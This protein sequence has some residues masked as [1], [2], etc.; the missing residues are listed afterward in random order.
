MLFLK[1]IFE[2]GAIKEMTWDLQYTDR[3]KNS[4]VKQFVRRNESLYVQE[5]RSLHLKET[6]L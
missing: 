3:K 5:I 1:N 4:I 6:P 2:I